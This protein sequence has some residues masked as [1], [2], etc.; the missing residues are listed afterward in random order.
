MNSVIKK[1]SLVLLGI[2]IL[3]VLLVSSTGGN[4]AMVTLFLD[5]PSLT[6][7]VFP[8]I[9]ILVFSGLWVDYIRAYKFVAGNKEFTTKE[10]KASVLAL[11]LGIKTTSILCGIGTVVGV[12]ASLADISTLEYLGVYLS[13][14]LI[15]VL[16]ALIINLI[17]IPI[18]TC[19][20]KE[21]L[22]R[23]N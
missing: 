1:I 8:L 16:Y 18:R 7:V 15:T 9:Y 19:I 3:G 13:I 17:Q 21:L 22:Y 14:L 20:K 12:I 23:E 5:I 4:L 6:I 11:D 2:L 10:L